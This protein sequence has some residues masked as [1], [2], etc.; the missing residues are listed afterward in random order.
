M[1]NRVP[2]GISSNW[3]AL[4]WTKRVRQGKFNSFGPA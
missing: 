3:S 1:H 4:H 2:D